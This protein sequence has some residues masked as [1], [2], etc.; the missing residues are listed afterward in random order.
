MSEVHGPMDS[1]R[2]PPWLVKRIAPGGSVSEVR[3]L[4]RRQSLHTVCESALCPNLGECFSRRTATFMILGDVC[5]RHCGYCAVA[6]GRP[7]PLDREEP[8]RVASAA[9]NLSLRHVVVT[10]VTRDDLPDG[11]ASH[12]A[13]TIRALRRRCPDAA[14][15]VLIPDFGGSEAALQ[16]VLDA[17]PDIVN[18][19]VETVPR[20]FPRVRPQGSYTISL[21]L[22]ARARRGLPGGYTKSGL[23]VGLGE[24]EE[25]VVQVMRDLREVG[26]DIFTV[27]QYLRPSRDH[28]EVQEYYPP[29]SFERMKA[30]GEALG[31][32]MVASGPFVRSSY[33]ADRFMPARPRDSGTI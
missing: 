9:A 31:F 12:F 7:Q 22:L 15:E 24:T 17:E 13:E 32:L 20:L 11:G 1:R 27:G 16:T 25:E 23:M 3:S 14:V 10:S 2:K 18:H 30:Q 26:C 4:L 6:S 5:T 33:Q 8:E 19:N 21:E 29:A 28:L